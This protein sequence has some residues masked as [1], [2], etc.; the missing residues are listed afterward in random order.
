[1]VEI[2]NVV[3]ENFC[4]V[5]LAK[6]NFSHWRIALRFVGQATNN[7]GKLLFVVHKKKFAD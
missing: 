4:F 6:K 5:G 2:F 3:E 1:M 7:A